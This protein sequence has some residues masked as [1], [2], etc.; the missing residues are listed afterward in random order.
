M[1]TITIDSVSNKDTY[2][3]YVN[4]F[5]LVADLIKELSVFDNLKII[6]S[7]KC[8]VVIYCMNL[9]NLTLKHGRILPECVLS[10]T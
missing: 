9:H 5:S 4:E 6:H 7:G 2:L 1:C 8:F 3:V 10:F